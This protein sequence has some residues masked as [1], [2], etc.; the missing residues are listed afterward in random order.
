M[1]GCLVGGGLVR[2]GICG[3][4]LGGKTGNRG[5]GGMFSSLML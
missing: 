2:G 1:T 5:G 3:G 4:R